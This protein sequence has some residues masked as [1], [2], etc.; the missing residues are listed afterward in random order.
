MFKQFVSYA[1]QNMTELAL[2][3][4][5][6]LIAVLT[7][8][9]ALGSIPH[10]LTWD[11]AAIGYNGFATTLYR[12]DEWLE[13]FPLSFRS[14]GDYKAPLAVYLTGPFTA[15]FGLS[16]SVFRFPFAVAGVIAV[17]GMYFLV[18]II[19]PE[20]AVARWYGLAAAFFLAVSPWHIHFSRAGFESGLSLALL[21]TG[22]AFWL[23]VLKASGHHRDKKT[24][25]QILAAVFL[26][27]GTLYAYHSAKIVTP[28][29]VVLT[30]GL[31]YHRSFYQQWR[32]LLPGAVLGAVAISPLLID[33]LYGNGAARASVFIFSSNLSV[34]E[35]IETI[36]QNFAAHFKPEYVVGGFVTNLRDGAGAWGILLPVTAV[37]FVL[38]LIQAIWNVTHAR[39]YSLE[40]L[41]LEVFALSWLII[42]ILP[43]AL[44]FEVP[45]PNRALLALPSYILLTLLGLQFL[46]H[47]L[48]R[49]TAL[50][51]I[52][53][54]VLGCLLCIH[55]FTVA[56]FWQYY[57]TRFAV[58]S[59]AAFNDG[60]IEA[61]ER[62]EAYEFGREGKP[63][64]S[65]ILMS[66]QYGQ[67]YIYG[68]F[69]KE[70]NPI[71]Y[72][73]GA[74]NTYRFVDKITIGDF[75]RKKTLLIATPADGL[76]GRQP[77]EV[78][79]GSDGK[80]RFLFYIT[81]LED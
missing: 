29:L 28:V 40:K 10:G 7:R 46:Y 78:V 26:L 75:E 56:S 38:G 9:T 44:T 35:M 24:N 36:G 41:Q 21:V 58:E 51:Y 60:Y 81:K 42:G 43:A 66:S 55:L 39:P 17:I 23:Q 57:V 3:S 32:W 68:L 47:R 30:L 54:S 34:V 18:R 25:L 4:I 1:K 20:R 76:S 33:L 12:R 31:Y 14:F 73:G 79:L 16:A 52:W 27:A 2:V 70:M 72:R 19:W 67:P 8:F 71:L 65:E 53:K 5:V 63:R 64:V 69:A 15:I 74:L 61:F 37:L 80:P 50:P 77:I 6:L 48:A 45:H 49:V 11:E 13:R 59:T 62:A 22:M